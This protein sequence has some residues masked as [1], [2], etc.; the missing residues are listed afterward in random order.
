[1]G[2]ILAARGCDSFPKKCGAWLT[3]QHLCLYRAKAAKG[4]MISRAIV[5]C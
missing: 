3:D 5:L 4:N 1:M 2:V